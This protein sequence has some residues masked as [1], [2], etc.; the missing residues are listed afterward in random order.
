MQNVLKEAIL[1]MIRDINEE[2]FQRV[3]VNFRNR[4]E[5][6]AQSTGFYLENI[7]KK[8]CQVFCIKVCKQ[9]L[10]IYFS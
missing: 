8:K 10:N 9:N 6:S 7:F 3:F 1:D 5:Y 4:M 2:K